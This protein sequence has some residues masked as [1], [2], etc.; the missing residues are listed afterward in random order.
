[1]KLGFEE[2]EKNEVGLYG[3]E[4]KIGEGPGAVERGVREAKENVERLFEI[5]WNWLAGAQEFGQ[6][7]C[8]AR[9]KR[10]ST[11][12]FSNHLFL[13]GF[14]TRQDCVVGVIKMAQ[15]ILFVGNPGVGKS[16]ILN[17]VIGSVCFKS[18][19]AFGRVVTT[20]CQVSNL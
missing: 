14:F 3:L 6:D 11:R 1:M 13:R 16:T 7:L 8:R 19:V 10:S 18:G 20:K 2:L 5:Q 15:R 17:S 12:T 4:N 9:Q